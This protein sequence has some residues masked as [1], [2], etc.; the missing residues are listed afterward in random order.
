MNVSK[1][2]SGWKIEL[3][4]VGTQVAVEARGMEG[5][6]WW[7]NVEWGEGGTVSGSRPTF[8][9]QVEEECLSKGEGKSQNEGGKLECVI[10]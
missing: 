7:Q 4:L 9:G 5:I 2:K 6:A 3:K 10:S 8:T 1:E